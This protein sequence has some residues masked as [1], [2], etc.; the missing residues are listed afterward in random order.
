MFKEQH[1]D[2]WS[3]KDQATTMEHINVD[4]YLSS[5]SLFPRK[6]Y[7]SSLKHTIIYTYNILIHSGL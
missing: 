6:I 5:K 2:T 4:R 3:R 7:V 1:V